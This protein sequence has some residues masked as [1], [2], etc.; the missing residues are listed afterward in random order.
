MCGRVNQSRPPAAL[1][2]CSFIADVRT[3]LKLKHW[4]GFAILKNMLM[5][6]KQFQCFISGIAAY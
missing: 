1:Y 6:L 3:S 5:R 2:N 4:N